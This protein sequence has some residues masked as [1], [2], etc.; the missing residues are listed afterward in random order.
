[1]L[2]QEMERDSLLAV[3]DYARNYPYFAPIFHVFLNSFVMCK[4]S[5]SIIF[6][7]HKAGIKIQKLVETTVDFLNGLPTSTLFLD[8]LINGVQQFFEMQ[9]TRL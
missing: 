6:T 9:V 5:A 4:F 2:G 3:L 7:A 1:M 8:F